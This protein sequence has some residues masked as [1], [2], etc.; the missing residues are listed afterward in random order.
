M[1]LWVSAAMIVGLF[2]ALVVAS[3]ARRASLEAPPCPQGLREDAARE[4]RIRALVVTLP[5]GAD[6]LRAL[7]SARFCFGAMSVPATMED[8][9][10]VLDAHASDAETAARVKHLLAHHGEPFAP[11]QGFD[12]SLPCAPQVSAAL[13]AEARA[14]VGEI[15]D[16]ARLAVTVPR[17]R[18]AFGGDVERAPDDDA[19][20]RI[21]RAF[22][23][24]HPDGGGGIDA[25]A[26]GYAAACARARHGPASDA[27]RR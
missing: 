24:A 20:V 10:L 5:H 13:D 15:A 4:S 7:P 26:T 3:R 25:L 27:G 9:R 23:D 8:A 19:R 18:F 1:R 17:L 6:W 21:V 16:R 2:V 12:A 11:V 14:L 22:L